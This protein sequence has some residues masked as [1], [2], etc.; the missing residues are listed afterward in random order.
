MKCLVGEEIKGLA[1]LTFLN[2]FC[3][4]KHKQGRQE[5]EKSRT[6]AP[7]RNTFSNKKANVAKEIG[8]EGKEKINSEA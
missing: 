4:K 6:N 2:E 1:R 8:V 5:N 3:R 7:R